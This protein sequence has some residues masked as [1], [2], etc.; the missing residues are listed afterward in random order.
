LD[1]PAVDSLCLARQAAVY[2]ARSRRGTL[3]NA[4]DTV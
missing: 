2:R 1:V 3:I 4:G